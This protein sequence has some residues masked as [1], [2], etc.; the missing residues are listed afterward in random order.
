MA[1]VGCDAG[2]RSYGV[3]VDE[4]D[5][6]VVERS[7]KEIK[8]FLKGLE[9]GSSIAVEATGRYH[10]MLAEMAYEKGFT[11]YVLNPSEFAL[12]RDSISWRAKTDP[13]DAQ[14]LS[15]YV[16]RE[17]DRLRAWVPPQHVP[18]RARDLLGLRDQTSTARIALEQSLK[19]I[20]L[21]SR[22]AARILQ[23]EVEKLRELEDQF[24]QEIAQLLAENRTF[25]RMLRAPGIAVLGAA[26]LTWIF[27]CGQFRSSDALIAFVGLDVRVRESGKW[28]GCRK[29]TK[30][31]D[32]LLRKILFN[33]A[34]SLRNSKRWKQCFLELAARGFS[35]IASNVYVMRKMLRLVWALEN[36]DTQYQENYVRGA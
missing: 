12:Y 29:L 25:R 14:I 21:K 24:E 16:A 20:G 4:G 8:E 27:S 30:R 9:K 5:P 18:R 7:P 28:R 15:R 10:L 31:G 26:I 35:S 1:Y 2:S 17:N 34:N 22:P 19:A 3:S 23:N 13:I 32:P 11:V 36:Y 33:G 6:F